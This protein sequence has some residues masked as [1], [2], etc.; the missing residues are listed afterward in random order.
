MD[1]KREALKL[2]P[3]MYARSFLD[4]SAPDPK[5]EI[6]VAALAATQTPEAGA[7]PCAGEPTMAG[8]SPQ[9]DEQDR[10]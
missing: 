7:R 2:R 3:L 10:P 9:S 5:A 6:S 8:V 1:K 4:D